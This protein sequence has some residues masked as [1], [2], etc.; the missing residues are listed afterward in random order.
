MLSVCAALACPTPGRL[1]PPIDDDG[2]FDNH[3]QARH[4]LDS[5]EK[6]Q[7]DLQN[8]Q[9]EHGVELQNLRNQHRELEQE[10]A[11][12]KSRQSNIPS[13]NLEIRQALSSSLQ[14]P[15]SSLPFA[16]ELLQLREEERHWESAIERVLHNFALSL[17]VP[18]EHYK[19]VAEYVERTH[20]KGRLVYYRVREPVRSTIEP[21]GGFSPGNSRYYSLR[22]D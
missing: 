20:L 12:L 2:F 22:P 6:D 13:R 17:L 5:L 11:S 10:I 16:G 19:S 7:A 3:Q 18:D 1:S 4:S 9:V 8:Q 15:E 21:A 14:L